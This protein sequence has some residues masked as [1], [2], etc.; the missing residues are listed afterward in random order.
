MKIYLRL[1]HHVKFSWTIV[2]EMVVGK[3]VVVGSSGGGGS[4]AYSLG[5]VICSFSR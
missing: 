4:K 2:G 3:V 5:I 1:I